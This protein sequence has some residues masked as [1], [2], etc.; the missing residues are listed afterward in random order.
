[1]SAGIRRALHSLSVHNYRRYFAGQVISISGTWMQT[2]AEMWLVVQL[3][4]SGVSVGLTAGLQFLPILLL[5]AYGGVLA[6]RHDKRRLLMIT[7]ALSALPALTLWALTLTGN[8][9]IWMVYALVL[10][11]GT[12]TA[13]D[14]P[15]RQSFVS[16]IVGPERVVNAVSLNSVIVHTSRIV[17]PALAGIVIALLGVAPCFLVNA[18]S[19]VAMIVA[20]RAMD[21]SQLMPPQRTE[22]ARGQ[23]R[24]ALAEVRRRPELR[25]PLGM[26]VVVGTLSFNFQVLLPLFADFT[27]HGTAASYALLTSAMGIGS[28]AGALAAGARNR[29]SPALLVVSSTLFGVASLAAA[30]APSLV[31]QALAL[32]PLGAASVTFASGVNSTLQ[33]AAGEGLRGRV[34][35]LYAV[36]FLGSTPIGAPIVGWL[37]GAVGPRAGLVL[38]G[39]AALIA[40]AGALVAYARAG[41]PITVRP[42]WLR[43]SYA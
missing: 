1:L 32:V 37:A 18:L 13:I 12:V 3:T 22:R 6:D 4:G 19:F 28:V 16:E 29:V 8:V 38:G 5:G 20:L 10:V 9:T 43:K 17:G 39:T 2:V 36:V 30:A 31:T 41:T 34:M 42:V 21:P 33:L 26:M 25:I 11:R 7:Q 14:N 24:M 27:W 23:I 40:A 15:A 35:A